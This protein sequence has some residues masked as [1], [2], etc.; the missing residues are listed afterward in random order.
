MADNIYQMVLA[1]G[2]TRAAEV[3]SRM[4]VDGYDPAL[5]AIG[6]ALKYAAAMYGA[7]EPVYGESPA[8]IGFW[9]VRPMSS[10]FDRNPYCTCPAC[11]GRPVG[12]GGTRGSGSNGTSKPDPHAD[13]REIDRLLEE[14]R[15]RFPAFA[16]ARKAALLGFIE[17]RAQHR[18]RTTATQ[19]RHLLDEL[20]HYEDLRGGLGQPAPEARQFAGEDAEAAAEVFDAYERARSLP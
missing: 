6:N 2:P 1:L 9:G 15:R 17:A 3:L 14:D 7:R 19:A 13:R 4:A 12:S 8:P 5:H 11:R 20:R 18:N 10:L 16:T